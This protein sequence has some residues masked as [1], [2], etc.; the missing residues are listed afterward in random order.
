MCI[1]FW[2]F[3]ACVLLTNYKVLRK[4]VALVVYCLTETA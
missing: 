2:V 3:C 1:Y 4:T